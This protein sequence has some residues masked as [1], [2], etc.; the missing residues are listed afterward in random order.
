MILR[1]ILKR[2]AG[3]FLIPLFHKKKLELIYSQYNFEEGGQTHSRW[4]FLGQGQNL[5]HSSDPSHYSDN[6][7]SLTSCAIRE[8]HQYKIFENTKCYLKL[9]NMEFKYI[10]YR[11]IFSFQYICLK[12]PHTNCF[13]K[14]PFLSQICKFV[15]SIPEHVLHKHKMPFW[16]N[17]ILTEHILYGTKIII[18]L[19]Y[20][21]N[22]TISLV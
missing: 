11:N 13:A 17:E 21:S 3:F 5:C 18:F 15:S 12:I 7:A 9:I 10:Y 4:K 8:L 6:T 14:K 22:E 2:H 16:F 1:I 19:K 20:Y